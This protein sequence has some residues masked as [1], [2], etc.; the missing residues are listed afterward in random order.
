LGGQ[1]EN[2]ISNSFT[3]LGLSALLLRI[4][5][6]QKYTEAT[7]IQTQAI[8]LVLAGRDI[9]ASAQT[10]TGKTAAFALPLL[11]RLAE[12]NSNTTK[13]VSVAP[14]ALILV[15][16]RELAAQVKDAVQTYGKYMPFKS[17]T[18]MGGVGY[19]AQAQSL[20]RGVDILI[21]TPGRLLDHVKQ[22]T[23]D[24]S[25]IEILVLDEADRMLDMGFIVD[26]RKIIGFVPTQRQTLMFSAT[27]T[28]EIR[29]LAATLLKD[30]TQI[31][32]AK[33]NEPIGLVTQ[34]AHPVDQEKKHGLL[35]H[36]VETNNWQQVLVF[37]RTK[38][39][40]D[41]LVDQLN[42]NGIETDAIHGDKSQHL[43]TRSLSR[44]KSGALRVLVATDIASRGIDIDT[45]PHVV[46][47]DMPHV[48][49][50]YVHRIGRTGRAGATGNAIS[51]IG[52]EDRTRLTAV[53]RLINRRVELQII[54]GFEPTHR[55]RAA[56]SSANTG[57][58][59]W[60]PRGQAPGNNNRRTAR[61][62]SDG[63]RRR[64]FSNAPRSRAA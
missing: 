36:L 61:P 32:V 64:Q 14:R 25:K 29:Q 62:V 37:T 22:R 13:R 3:S 52:E 54:P 47:Y 41:R 40:A 51:L 27:F 58:R 57:R 1:Q 4:V 39:G 19:G 35:S 12:K 7:P 15:P 45:L 56:K 59:E 43:R 9:L 53:E 23:V 18:I 34:I 42:R 21:A 46:N 2:I 33:R 17:L 50:D 5:A 6:E 24:L 48:A 8:P 11:Q 63:N 16:T 44:F 60:Q 55:A 49:E 10:G 28:P 20:R 30:A 26:I 31:D 38:R